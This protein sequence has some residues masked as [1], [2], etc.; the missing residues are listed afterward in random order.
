M[1]KR[2]FFI[3][4][5]VAIFSSCSE[6]QKVLK[7]SDYDLKYEK[8]LEYYAEE[9]YYRSLS[10]FE[11][12]ISLY[13]GTKKSENIAYH[14]SYCH[15][16]QRDYILAGYHFKNFAQTFP[17]SDNAEECEYMSAYCHYLVSPKE[18]LDQTSSYKAIE[19]L[20]LFLNK[21]PNSERKDEAN[22]LVDKLRSKLETK[23]YN[24][25]KIYFDLGYYNSAIVALQ[26]SLKEFPD[27]KYR[28]ELL[29]LIFKSQYLYADGSVEIKKDDRF[30]K[31]L[32]HYY[33]YI[34]AYPDGEFA[35]EA[36]QIYDRTVKYLNQ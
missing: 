36:E 35:K 2:F 7:S 3:L 6:F 26:N 8:A 31:A 14:Y 28:E 21:Y 12:L 34:D 20:Q 10:L 18:S 33:T 5:T 22:E 29:F 27:T 24:N 25:S 13:R 1:L 23:S 30:E 17:N 32:D 19:A 11:E 9:D 15:Y 16:H 4:I